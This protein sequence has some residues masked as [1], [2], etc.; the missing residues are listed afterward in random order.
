VFHKEQRAIGAAEALVLVV[1]GTKMTLV[2]NW[3]MPSL[4]ALT[5]TVSLIGGSIA[6]SLHRTRAMP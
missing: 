1:V 4:L 5:I 6:Y 3:K 2:D